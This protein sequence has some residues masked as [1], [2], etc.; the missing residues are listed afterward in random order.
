MNTPVKVM[1]PSASPAAAAASARIADSVAQLDTRVRPPGGRAEARA[2][3][4]MRMGAT[5][6]P[7]QVKPVCKSSFP[8][9]C[10]PRRAAYAAAGAAAILCFTQR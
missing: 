2:A 7:R 4:S 6:P 9:G 3:A 5:K 1:A 10:H 8:T